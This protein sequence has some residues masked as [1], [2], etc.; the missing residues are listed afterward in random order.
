MA[1]VVCNVGECAVVGDEIVWTTDANDDLDE[2]LV[3][4]YTVT[5]DDPDVDPVEI[6]NCVT[7]TVNGLAFPEACH[8]L[9]WDDAEE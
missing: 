8:T 5:L 1:D 3:L 4:T 2:D 7:G 9:E 6:P